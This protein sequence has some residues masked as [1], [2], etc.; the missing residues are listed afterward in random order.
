MSCPCGLAASY[1]ECCGRFH[2][3][4]AAPTPEALM[5]SRYAAFVRQEIDY[6]VSTHHPESREH[7]DV[8]AATAWSS[9]SQ[10]L[11][12]DVLDSTADG[13]RGTVEFVARYAVDGR[14]MS[15]HELSRFV[16][17]DGHWF[18]QDGDVVRPKPIVKD[19]SKVGRN[20]PCPCGSGKKYKKCC[21]R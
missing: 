18:Y 20:E 17:I 7:M 9:Q 15:H 4:E 8:D 16:K 21:G 12:L 10:W 6:I 13:D 14:E 2:A 5:R 19:P 3:G 11:G 1:E